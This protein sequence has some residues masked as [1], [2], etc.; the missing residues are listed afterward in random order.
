M[1]R[2]LNEKWQKIIKACAFLLIGLAFILVPGTALAVTLRIIGALLLVYQVLEIY[3]IIRANKH[4]PMLALFLVN[5]IFLALLAL[6]LVTNPLGAV[7][8][9]ALV[10]GIYFL[11]IGAIGLYRTIGVRDTRGIVIN[12]ISAVVGFLLLVLPYLFQSV[13]TIILGVALIIKGVDLLL[14]LINN[15]NNSDNDTYYM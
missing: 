14:P 11:I 4:S 5:E 9:L 6:M 15:T 8:T 7:K 1:R 3:E 12:A 10:I 2:F 13:I